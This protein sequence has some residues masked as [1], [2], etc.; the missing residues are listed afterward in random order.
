MNFNRMNKTLECVKDLKATDITKSDREFY[1][2]QVSF[3]S[4]PSKKIPC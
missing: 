2:T 3:K 4:S 1:L